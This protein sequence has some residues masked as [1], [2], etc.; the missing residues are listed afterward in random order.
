[1]GILAFGTF[2]FFFLMRRVDRY[3]PCLLSKH[4]SLN[5]YL[6]LTR[7]IFCLHFAVFLAFLA[8]LFDLSQLLLRGS[9]TTTDGT[10]SDLPPGGAGLITARE[11]FYALSNSSRF[12]FYWGF[13][14][15][16]PLGET[17]PEGNKMH[18]GSWRRWGRIGVV[19]KW[20]TLFIQVVMLVLQLLYRNIPQ[21]AQIG[22]V[23]EAESTLE[24][25]LSAVFILKLLLNT[26]AMCP[27]GTSTQS[28]GKMLIQYT[29]AIIALLFSL[30][31]AVGNA[32]LCR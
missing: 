5:V 28:K 10:T 4:H 22:P 20:L 18:S 25:I 6:I 31:I 27:V 9:T 17:I 8:A 11:V 1:M 7:W 19:L 24:I 23:Y 30:W 21:L 29:P 32:I 13:V 14:A 2:T 12:L 26:L 15:M 3:V 16:I